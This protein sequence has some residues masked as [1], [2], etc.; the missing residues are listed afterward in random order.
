EVKRCQTPE[1]PPPGPSASHNWT[2][3]RADVGS[4]TQLACFA[5]PSR[6]TGA[7]LLP[8]WAP[9]IGLLGGTG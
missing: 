5:P 3:S 8:G 9:Q 7:D 2:A 6:V 4:H 1:A